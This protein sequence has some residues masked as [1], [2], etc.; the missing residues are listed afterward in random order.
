MNAHGETIQ[1]AKNGI[2]E[3]HTIEEL[4]QKSFYESAA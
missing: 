3:G 4:N 1:N 2:E